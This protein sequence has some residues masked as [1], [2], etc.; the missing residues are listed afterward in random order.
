MLIVHD[1]VL[2][3]RVL[4]AVGNW[5]RI[6]VI[7]RIVLIIT[8]SIAHGI[9]TTVVVFQAFV[10]MLEKRCIEVFFLIRSW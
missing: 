2:R 10:A 5:G 8:G 7:T 1:R 3:L 4:F 6:A 9:S